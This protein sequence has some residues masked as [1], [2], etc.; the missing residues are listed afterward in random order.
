MSTCAGLAVPVLT[1]VPVLTILFGWFP[2]ALN[3]DT[4]IGITIYYAALNFLSFYSTPGA[5]TRRAL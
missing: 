2:I 1:L 5:T 3:F 4:V